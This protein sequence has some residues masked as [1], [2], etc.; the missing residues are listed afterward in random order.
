MSLRRDLE[1]LKVVDGLVRGIMRPLPW[2]KP[3]H[4]GALV[5]REDLQAMRHVKVAPHS[6]QR[7]EYAKLFHV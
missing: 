7:V 4:L 6:V 1:I 5:L 2:R 3:D